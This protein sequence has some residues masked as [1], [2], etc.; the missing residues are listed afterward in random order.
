MGRDKRI[1]EFQLPLPLDA[2]LLPELPAD[3]NL[4][5]TSQNLITEIETVEP[6]LDRFVTKVE[7]N[8]VVRTPSDAGYF[9]LREVFNPFEAFE[10]EELYVL[11]LNMKNRVTHVAMIYRGTVSS[12]FVREA[13]VLRPAVRLNA[14]SILIAHNHPSGLPEPSPEDV[15]FSEALFHAGRLLKIELL[16]HLIIG[17]GRWVSLRERRL[18]FE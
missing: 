9:L 8:L 15:R 7:E 2:T 14:T 16:D 1:S 17:D 4:Y 11:M 3:P 13:E 18:G 5:P 6:G 10:Q 12:I